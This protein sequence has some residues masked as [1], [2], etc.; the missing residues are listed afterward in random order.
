[1]ASE[2]RAEM[3]TN[4]QFGAVFARTIDL[5]ESGHTEYYTIET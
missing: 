3:F 5:V 4:P 1:M 2:V